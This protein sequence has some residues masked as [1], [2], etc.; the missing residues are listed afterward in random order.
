MAL[1][2]SITEGLGLDNWQR[3]YQ[4]QLQTLLRAAHP[5]AN[6]YPGVGYVP[7]VW[8]A[9]GWMQEAATTDG[10]PEM[11]RTGLG[12]R[13]V[14][15]AEGQHVTWPATT[16]DTIWLHYSQGPESF[17]TFEVL[18]DGRSAATMATGGDEVISGEILELTPRGRPAKTLSVRATAGTC[19][20]EGATFLNGAGGLYLIDGS[21]SGY[22]ADLYTEGDRATWHW[23]AAEAFDVAF[24]TCM[25]GANDMAGNFDIPISP[26]EWAAS[27]TQLVTDALTACPDAGFYFFHW[28]ERYEDAGNHQLRDFQD[29]ALESIGGHP[30]TSCHLLSDVLPPGGDDTLGWHGMDGEDR[31]HPNELGHTFLAHELARVL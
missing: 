12:N 16:C 29:A 18:V 4:T 24:F 27:L 9:H 22:R 5:A 3:R 10:E 19:S 15:L 1:G 7:A 2:D 26:Q 31:V 13:L 25:L 11:D 17:G 30:R 8:G 20:I 21:H 6:N 23:Q 28:T 14:R